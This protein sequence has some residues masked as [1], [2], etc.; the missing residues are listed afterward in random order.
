[1]GALS[2]V[3][4]RKRGNVYFLRYRING[5]RFEE[6]L[7]TTRLREAELVRAKREAEIFEGRWFPDKARSDLSVDQLRERWFKHAVAK[8]SIRA[9]RERFERIVAFFGKSSRVADIDRAAVVDFRAAL[10]VTPT[11][12]RGVPSKTG[13][14]LAASTV[15]RHLSLLRSALRLAEKDGFVVQD[16]FGSALLLE[17]DN[18][19][20]RLCSPAELARIVEAA[21]VDVGRLVTLLYWTAC[22]LSEVATLTWGQV[23]LERAMLQLRWTKTGKRRD[24]PVPAPALAI[25]V[26]MS[27]ERAPPH[28][29][30]DRLFTR[31]PDR[32][33][34]A[35]SRLTDRL[36]VLDLHLHDL[37]HTAL[38][39]LRRAGV[40]VLTMQRI[41]GHATLAM[42]ARYNTV[43]EEDLLQAV[44]RV[45]ERDAK[46]R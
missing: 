46:S 37:R 34:S 6:S 17:E 13:K 20:D 5:Q 14:T 25:L 12:N 9:D 44:A 27:A 29:P 33:S 36:S 8:R 15:N 3:T 40:D 43:D 39:R 26:A 11:M 41:S 16:A 1:M 7:K 35:F 42:L 31:D 18:E 30:T 22:R 4:I 28:A 38:T 21:E 45:V 24:V 2:R 32:F 19:R 23:D 10:L